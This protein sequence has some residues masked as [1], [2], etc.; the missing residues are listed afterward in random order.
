MQRRECLGDAGEQLD[1]RP[2]QSMP[3][4]EEREA[5]AKPLCVWGWV[6]PSEGPHDVANK[7]RQDRRSVVPC[8][9]CRAPT[10]R[11]RPWTD[12]SFQC[13]TGCPKRA[14]A[15]RGS[16]PFGALVR[17]KHLAGATQAFDMTV[18]SGHGEP[19][20]SLMV[21]EASLLDSQAW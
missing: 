16:W 10:Q 13:E 2:K 6:T 7:G 1:F 19:P 4:S 21:S 14:R 11:R 17:A 18:E 5:L 15:S 9:Q 20:I 8:R 3:L 12:S